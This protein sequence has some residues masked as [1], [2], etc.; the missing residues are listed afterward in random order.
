MLFVATTSLSEPAWHTKARTQRKYDRLLLRTY[1]QKLS[2]AETAALQAAAHRLDNHHG[3]SSGMAPWGNFA[4]NMQG[5]GKG[6]QQMGQW[7]WQDNPS[8]SKGGSN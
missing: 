8:C 2:F 1:K 3:S 7:I 5:K 6:K 4:N